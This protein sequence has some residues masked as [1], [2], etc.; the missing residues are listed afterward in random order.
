LPR[1]RQND[2]FVRLLLRSTKIDRDRGSKFASYD[3][4]AVVN[5]ASASSNG[6]I[7]KMFLMQ[8]LR[9]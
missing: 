9:I 6:S 1:H 4:S 5:E 3:A 2:N 7:C 8:E